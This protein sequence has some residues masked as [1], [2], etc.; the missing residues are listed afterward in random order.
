M[1]PQMAAS[2]ITHTSSTR[3]RHDAYGPVPEGLEVCHNCNV[4][5]C[6][7]P[8]H[9]RADSHASNMRDA[10]N[11]GSMKGTPGFGEENGLAKLTWKAL[12]EI[13]TLYAT[14][15][16]TQEGLASKFGVVHSTINR[17]VNNRIWISQPE[18]A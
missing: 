6:V 18:M 8:I 1:C 17:I 10:A 15:K 5:H 13:R 14:G 9:L 3:F 12:E 2:L 4:R 7:R 16:H 11:A